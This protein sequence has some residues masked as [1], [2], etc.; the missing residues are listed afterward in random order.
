MK[1]THTN[2]CQLNCIKQHVNQRYGLKATVRGG[3]GRKRLTY[4]GRGRLIRK[5]EEEEHMKEGK[6]KQIRKEEDDMQC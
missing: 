2:S 3:G 5:K 4:E 6:G 1:K